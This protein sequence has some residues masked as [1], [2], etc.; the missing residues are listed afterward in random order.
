MIIALSALIVSIVTVAISIYS[1][2][3][4]RAYAR[5]SFWPRLEIYRSYNQDSFNYG[6]I[7]SGNGPALVQYAVVRYQGTAIKQWTD[8]S[9][10][11]NF[12]QTQMSRRIISPQTTVQPLTAT[13]T[14]ADEF[15]KY[16]NDIS[17]ELCYCSI[18]DECW[19]TD[20]ANLPTA[21]DECRVAEKESFLQ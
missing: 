17:I 18:Y 2:Y 5:A 14:R 7:N 16:D 10:L 12:I 6:I 9:G 8:I 13:H 20:R 19:L 1:A 15:L 4:D 11:P 21:V 3:I